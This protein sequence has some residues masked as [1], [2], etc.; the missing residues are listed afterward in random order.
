MSDD[1]RD[2]ARW[3]LIDQHWSGCKVKFDVDNNVSRLTLTIDLSKPGGS[4]QL[5]AKMIDDCIAQQE[6]K[7]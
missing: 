5:L 2:A 6:A 7:P 3:R 4:G 1:A